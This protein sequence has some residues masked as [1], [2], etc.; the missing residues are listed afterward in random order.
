LK[1]KYGKNII[2]R[3]SQIEKDRDKNGEKD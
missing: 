1:A 2:T 3:G